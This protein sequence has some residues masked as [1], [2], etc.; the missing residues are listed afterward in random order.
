MHCGAD[1]EDPV[2]ADTGQPIEGS[3][4]QRRTNSGA[5]G[6]SREENSVGP[7]LAGVGVA[8]VALVTL[9]WAS[10]SNTTLFYLAA[11]VGIGV[12]ASRQST[13]NEALRKAGLALAIA[14]FLLWLLS[15]LFDGLGSFSL[16]RLV[17]PVIY[18][19][20]VTVITRRLTD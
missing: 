8:F 5:V 2:D 1:F 15:P 14:P 7:K 17:N 20:V 13:A 12:Y 9:P 10:P 4:H 6:A 11:V 3:D 16:S 19:V 18:A